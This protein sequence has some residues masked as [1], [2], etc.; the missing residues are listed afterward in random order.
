[1]VGRH[2]KPNWQS[3]EPIFGSLILAVFI[4][5]LVLVIMCYGGGN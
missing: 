5:L 3:M 1:M 2:A 4:T